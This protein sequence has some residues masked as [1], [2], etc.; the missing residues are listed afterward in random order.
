MLE[1]YN[2]SLT[3]LRHLS[4]PKL[5]DKRVDAVCERVKIV[6]REHFSMSSTGFPRFLLLNFRKF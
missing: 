6:E 3:N 5:L 1:L 2:L 4:N